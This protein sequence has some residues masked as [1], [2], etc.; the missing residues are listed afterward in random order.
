VTD[1]HR[2]DL[3]RLADV[4]DQID[5]FDQHLE[6]ALQ[7][8]QS[9]VDRLHATWTGEAATKHR[10]AHDEWVRGV[11]DMRTALKAMRRNAQIAHG[12]YHGAA[13]TNARMWEQ[14]R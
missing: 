4:V 7:D 5:R 12:N 6:T 10:Q 8:A 13:T 2:V 1:R 9:R 3:P 14:A 11:A